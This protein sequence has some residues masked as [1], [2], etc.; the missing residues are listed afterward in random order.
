MDAMHQSART[1]D[2]QH[3]KELDLLWTGVIL[4]DKAQ[5]DCQDQVLKDRDF[6]LDSTIRMGLYDNETANTFVEKLMRYTAICL[7]MLYDHIVTL[8]NKVTRWLV[9]L[10]AWN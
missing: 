9:S 3:L 4:A 10:L 5:K 2:Y 7:L 8:E 6:L 1:A